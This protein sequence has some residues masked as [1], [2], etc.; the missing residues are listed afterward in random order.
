MGWIGTWKC[1]HRGAGWAQVSGSGGEGEQD[2]RV[3][4]PQ[5][6]GRSSPAGCQG[7]GQT[8]DPTPSR[9]P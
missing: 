4:C 1:T 9:S 5:P 6:V 2:Q 3:W 8:G 7:R